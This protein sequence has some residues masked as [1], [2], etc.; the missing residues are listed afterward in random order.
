[1]I[2]M[3]HGK[4]RGKTIELDDDLGIP[5]GQEVEVVVK[6]S[7]PAEAWGEGI[8]RSAGVAADV[9]GFD[10]VFAEIE[11]ERKSARFREQDE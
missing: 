7:R 10:E 8:K 5:D 6:V 2:R 3:S 9:V 4:V 11:R 1:M